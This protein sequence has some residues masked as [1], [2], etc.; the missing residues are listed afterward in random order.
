MKNTKVLLT[1]AAFMLLFT[2]GSFAQ[3][4]MSVAPVTGMGFSIHNGSD[5]DQSG[6][7]FGVVAGGLIDMQFNQSVGLITNFGFYDNRSGS[8]ED[9]ITFQPGVVGTVENS[10]SLSYFTIE[11]L[12]KFQFPSR[13]YLM[14]G[15]SLGFNLSAENEIV[16]T[17]TTPDWTFDGENKTRKSKGTIRNTNTRFELKA[18]AGYNIRVANGFDIAP[19]ITFGY[20][21]TNVVEDVEWKIL[22]IQAN[23]AFK[24]AV[25]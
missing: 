16:E 21:L 9:D 7:G 18:G 11:P 14:I 6:N 15:P 20:G 19:Q 4:K 23:V 17:I 1:V 5:L 10:V 24:F 8:Y 3:F 13:F 2:S 12:F 25:M 22:T